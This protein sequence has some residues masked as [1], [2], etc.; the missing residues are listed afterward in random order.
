MFLRTT[1]LSS[2]VRLNGVP[3]GIWST[4][5]YSQPS[6]T[7]RYIS[8][9]RNEVWGSSTRTTLFPLFRGPFAIVW[10]SRGLFIAGGGGGGG[11]G[12]AAARGVHHRTWYVSFVP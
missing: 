12:A 9:L 10:T 6:P 5:E 2:S 8:T 11:G 7:A 1:Q 3:G 4:L